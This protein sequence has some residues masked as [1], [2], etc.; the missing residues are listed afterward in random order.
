MTS[1]KAGGRLLQSCVERVGARSGTRSQ[2]GRFQDWLVSSE[3]TKPRA[4]AL[5]GESSAHVSFR[6]SEGRNLARLIVHSFSYSVTYSFIQEILG[7]I[8]VLRGIRC[9]PISRS[10]DECTE[11]YNTVHS[12][13][14]NIR[15][16]VGAR[17]GA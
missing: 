9:T 7:Y 3:V 6:M 12:E 8:Y 1:L 4:W 2:R 10:E 5:A 17:R 15:A 11:N 16:A 14:I 13:M